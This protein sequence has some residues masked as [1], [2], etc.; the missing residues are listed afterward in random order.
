MSIFEVRAGGAGNMRKFRSF[1]LN[2]GLIVVV[3]FGGLAFQSRNMIA[4]DGQAA[5][6]LRGT[7]L[8]GQPYDLENAAGRPAL[9]YFF[10]P[11]CLATQTSCGNGRFTRSL[12]TTCWTAGTAWH[13]AMSATAVNSGCGCARG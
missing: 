6:Q 7:T 12:S 2:A 10:A 9:V 3:F 8:T 5:P 4:A 1:L 13:D 11:S